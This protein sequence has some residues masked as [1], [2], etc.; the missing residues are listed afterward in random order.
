MVVLLKSPS[1]RL[2]KVDRLGLRASGSGN[3]FFLRLRASGSG[4]SIDSAILSGT[5]LVWVWSCGNWP[6]KFLCFCLA[7][8]PNR[9]GVRRPWGKLRWSLMSRFG[10]PR[11]VHLDGSLYGPSHHPHT[12]SPAPDKELSLGVLHSLRSWRSLWGFWGIVEVVS[13]QF[14]F[15]FL[16]VFSWSS[17]VFAPNRSDTGG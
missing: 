3:S 4:L 6:L 10:D 12:R 9:W 11:S 17:S 2:W 1:F 15:L 7:L 14:I 16:D 8:T 5:F 13:A